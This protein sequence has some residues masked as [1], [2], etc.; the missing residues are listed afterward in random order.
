M[1]RVRFFLIDEEFYFCYGRIV[2]GGTSGCHLSCEI[3]KFKEVIPLENLIIIYQDKFRGAKLNFYI[4]GR[5]ET[6]L[7]EYGKK[8]TLKK[9][10]Y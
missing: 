5:L 10:L 6:L 4:K 2:R 9:L 3:C 1:K 8:L 7:E